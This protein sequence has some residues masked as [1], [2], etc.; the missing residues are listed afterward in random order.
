MLLLLLPLNIFATDN[1]ECTEYD[2][3]VVCKDTNYENYN[4]KNTLFGCFI[5]V[6]F[7]FWFFIYQMVK[8]AKW[9]EKDYLSSITKYTIK[10]ICWLWF[11]FCFYMFKAVLFVSKSS[12]F[13]EDKLYLINLISYLT[14]SL[15]LFILIA[16]IIRFMYSSSSIEEI[17]KNLIYEVKNGRK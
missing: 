6:A 4:I 2:T 15:L 17:F 14:A 5:V 12:T 11:I 10:L 1:I 13:L 16:N 3:Y 9:N 8:D 7:G